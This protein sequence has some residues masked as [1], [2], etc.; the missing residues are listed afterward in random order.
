MSGIKDSYRA[1]AFSDV[2]ATGEQAR[3][4]SYLD[5]ATD[6]T[7]QQKQSRYPLLEL[8]AGDHVLDI[9]C[10]TG[11]DVAELAAL[12]GRS[13]RAVGIDYSEAMVAEARKRVADSS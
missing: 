1:H 12:V 6:F 10:G 11:A 7:R 4:V 5:Q 3:Y 9:G 2:D 13:G 8:R